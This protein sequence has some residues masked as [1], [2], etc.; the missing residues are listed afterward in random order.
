MKKIILSVIAVFSLLAPTLLITSHASAATCPVKMPETLLSLYRHSQAIYIGRFS[1]TEKG[2]MTRDEEHYTV[3]ELKKHFEIASALKGDAV[4]IFT[5]MDSEFVYKHQQAAEPIEVISTVNESAESNESDSEIVDEEDEGAK[6]LTPGDS[7]L[8]FL[9]QD[10]AGEPMTLTD[11]SDGIKNLPVADIAVYEARIRE[12][13]AILAVEKP[14]IE[15]ITDWLVKCA[16]SPVTRWEGTYEL[17]RSF[18]AMEYKTAREAQQKEKIAKGETVDGDEPDS[19]DDEYFENGLETGRNIAYASS[20]N[21]HQKQTL[22]NILLDSEFQAPNRGARLGR[23]DR[24]LMGLVSRWADDRIAE[25]FLGR[26]RGGSYSEEENHQL[27]Q[28]VATILNDGQIGM[29]TQRFG[30]VYYADD[31]K[32]VDPDDLEETPASDESDKTAENAD[33]PVAANDVQAVEPGVERVESAAGAEP[34]QGAEPKKPV[35]TYKE[36]RAALIAKFLARADQVMTNP[37]ARA[38]VAK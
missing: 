23:G 21:A 14:D 18:E 36:L 7:V 1:G 2:K 10:E 25:L 9:R 8:L 11:Y 29:I 26:L 35:M 3:F 15:K 28:A 16:E 32:Q 5:L 37:D 33:A 34:D 6:E 19:D 31:D 30:N 22:A 12:L 13:A 38:A 20:L 27:M 17:E 4:K 24:E